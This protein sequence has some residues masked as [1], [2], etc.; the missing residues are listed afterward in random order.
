MMAPE[1]SKLPDGEERSGALSVLLLNA[2]GRL[3]GASAAACKLLGRTQERLM[4]S[5]LGDL[6]GSAAP[7]MFTWISQLVH[8]QEAPPPRMM[9][10]SV[11]RP[12][13]TELV[14]DAVLYAVTLGGGDCVAG[15]RLRP[16]QTLAIKGDV[17]RAQREV[18][19]LI[20]SGAGLREAMRSAAVFAE[21]V[22][23]GEI[24]CMVSPINESGVFERGVCPT[25]PDELAA[26]Q[27][28][29]AAGEDFSPSVQAAG[30]VERRIAASLQSWPAYHQRLKHHGLVAAWALPIR[31]SRA[32]RV[33]AVLEFLLP[34]GRAPTEAEDLMLEDVSE[35]VRLAM[36]LHAMANDV[37][38]RTVAQRKA[39]TAAQDRGVLI[40]AMLDATMDAV[41]CMDLQGRVTLWN[42]CAE[43]LFGWSAAEVMQQPLSKFI[44]PPELVEA[45]EK[46]L[47][48]FRETGSGPVIGRRIEILA[49][50]RGGHRFPVELSINRI[51]G[52]TMHFS[53]YLR[54]I[55]DRRR[56]E[57]A[58][59]QS[60]QRLKHV[61]DAIADG[62]WDFRL[63]GGESEMSA[64]CAT[65]LG[66]PVESL[67]ITLPPQHPWVHPEDR[68]IV[69]K[70]WNDHLRGVTPRYECEHR[71]QHADGSWRWIL[72]SGR[73]VERDAQQRPVR[74]SGIQ[75]DVSDRRALEASV[76]SAERLESLGLLASG[77]AQEL[78]GLLNDIRG[79]AT[80]LGTR[81]RGMSGVAEAIAEPLREIQSNVAKAKSMAQ[82]VIALSPEAAEDQVE[83]VSAVQVVSR[84]RELAAPTLPRTMS[85]DVQDHTGG[86]DLVRVDVPKL[87]QAILNLLLRGC[88]VGRRTGVLTLR[89][90]IV[91]APGA[92]MVSI[93]CIDQAPPMAPQALAQVFE[94]L[95]DDGTLL[96]RTALGMAAV[97]RF[98][99]SA[100]GRVHAVALERGNA[101]SI[102]LP[103]IEPAGT[104]RRLGVAL[105]H[106]QTI[107]RVM[108]TVAFQ[109][110]GHAVI[111]ITGDDDLEPVLQQADSHSVL[112]VGQAC[113]KGVALERIRAAIGSGGV[114]GVVVLA[115]G[116]GPQVHEPGVAWVASGYRLED[117]L[118][119]VDRIGS[120]ASPSP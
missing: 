87:Q 28:G 71:R 81:V 97:K 88:E 4:G 29:H 102:S 14:L 23:P 112:V 24:F 21:R 75:V 32:P 12:D 46:G 19:H 86:R 6:F 34:V 119:L 42:R 48:R 66:H 92:D 68:G 56:S 106:P 84:T 94:A 111:Q 38:A 51:L 61:I 64:R 17:L 30:G 65:M 105:W 3:T 100:H 15:L 70:A 13:G 104:V 120:G 55:S 113:W 85:L 57:A 33:G 36:D 99:E 101:V 25:L 27:A 116:D 79:D 90:S 93:E 59:K 52:S 20:S 31:G 77:F 40:D 22:L 62:L 91:G 82:S 26:L 54:D 95:S 11:L 114:A 63:D 50:N 76:A 18:L 9:Q 109:D 118:T 44:I 45:H 72:D 74:V 117:L 60:E 103:L 89:V 78:Y 83:T 69:A 2:D 43:V 41:I 67:P 73:V 80:L 107:D 7:G 49:I 115:D 47:Q 39:E 8:R 53:A 110:A 1:E 108:L 35:M 10:L 96:E 98:A 16:N 58:L 5:R 37:A